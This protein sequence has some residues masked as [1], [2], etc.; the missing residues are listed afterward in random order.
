VCRI[1]IGARK[2]GCAEGQCDDSS[3]DARNH[4]RPPKSSEACRRM[5]RRGRL[6][7]DCAAYPLVFMGPSVRP[8]GLERGCRRGKG[9]PL[10]VIYTRQPRTGAAQTLGDLRANRER[11][12][13]RKGSGLL[14]AKAEEN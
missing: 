2:V 6:S 4:W 3:G 9:R 8:P 1:G 11:R 10:R 13:D 7:S 12:L 14:L 5:R